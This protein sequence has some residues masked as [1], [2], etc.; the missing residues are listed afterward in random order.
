MDIMDREDVSVGSDIYVQLIVAVDEES[1]IGVLYVVSLSSPFL[2]SHLLD[3]VVR[4]QL[5]VAKSE[6]QICNFYEYIME[7]WSISISG[8]PKSYVTVP[9]EKNR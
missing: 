6:N 5:M 2:L 9:M 4:N 8:T 7:R 1:N 3:N